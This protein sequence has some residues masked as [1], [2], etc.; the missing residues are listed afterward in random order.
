MAIALVIDC[1]LPRCSTS[2]VNERRPARLMAR[3][4]A[5]AIITVEIFVEEYIFPVRIVLEYVRTAVNRAMTVFVWQE[6][7]DQA[8]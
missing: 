4:E 1:R 8:I 5:C 3:A 6:D 2:F 7:V